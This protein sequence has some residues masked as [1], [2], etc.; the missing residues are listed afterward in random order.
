[1]TFNPDEEQEFTEV[2]GEELL[3]SNLEK[4]YMKNGIFKLTKN[5]LKSAV[6]YGLVAVAVVI[7]SEG[8][9][10]GLDWKALTDVGILAVLTS[11]VKNL[12]TTDTSEFLGIV[13]T[14]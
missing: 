11:I 14:H 10:F 13:K 5:N 2:V 6:V 3:K 8:T 9:I 4:Q 1:M 7:I 12:L